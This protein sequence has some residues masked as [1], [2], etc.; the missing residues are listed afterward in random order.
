MTACWVADSRAASL[1]EVLTQPYEGK[2]RPLASSMAQAVG[3]SLPIV[4]VSPDIRYEYDYTLNSYVRHVSLGGELFVERAET[5]GRGHWDLSLVYQH[6]RFD[7]FGGQDLHELSDTNA[8][9]EPS[10]R[11]PLLSIDHSSIDVEVNEAIFNVIH[12]VSDRFDLSV[13]APLITSS[14]DVRERLTIFGHQPA[15]S[16]VQGHFS[17]TSTGV[18]DVV[19]RSKAY[20]FSGDR[21]LASAGISVTVPTGSLH[22]LQGV[23][24]TE[25]TP[26]LFVSSRE[27]ALRNGIGMRGEVN[28][29]MVLDTGDVD[30]SESRWAIAGAF[31]FS[32]R[33]TLGVGLLGRDAVRPLFSDRSISFPRCAPTNDRCD[34]V[35]SAPLLGFSGR[36]PDY[37][38]L[39]VG[40]RVLL[41]RDSLVGFANVLVPLSSEG[42]I[43]EPTP[44]V[45]IELSL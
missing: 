33:A 45:G 31:T 8:I 40:G 34:S 9:I 18:G 4:A 19:L 24:V 12:G 21:I 30:R 10:T 6:V 39:S 32:S 35:A 26:K 43:A 16:H 36:R 20:V 42:L 41:W 44:V 17:A 13:S 23:G 27:R 2:L 14:L 29:A 3:R 15:P 7:R 28:L 25:V 38:D 22:N 37:L 11:T 1:V 5:I